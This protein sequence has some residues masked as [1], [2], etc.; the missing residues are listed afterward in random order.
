[1]Y[2]YN[3]ILVVFV[4][5]S[6]TYLRDEFSIICIYTLEFWNFDVLYIVAQKIETDPVLLNTRIPHSTKVY[7][8]VPVTGM[9]LKQMCCTLTVLYSHAFKQYR[10]QM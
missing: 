3:K 5:A 10:C 9:C 6:H 4:C 8:S 1:M 2:V 7:K